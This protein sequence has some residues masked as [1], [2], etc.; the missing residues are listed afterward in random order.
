MLVVHK[1]ILR[2]LAEFAWVWSTREQ[3]GQA[4]SVVLGP[5]QR[6]ISFNPEYSS[7]T[8]AVRGCEAL[9]IGHHHYWELKM[10]SAVYGT[11]IVSVV[12]RWTVSNM[13][14]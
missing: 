1:L 4:G 9:P 12:V 6:Q 8:A 5:D 14:H 11:D 13:L 10:T 7:G 3:G 2:T